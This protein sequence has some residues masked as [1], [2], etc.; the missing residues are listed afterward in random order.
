MHPSQ[1]KLSRNCH[2]R[3][4]VTC[5][6]AS[7]SEPRFASPPPDGDHAATKFSWTV[8]VQCGDPSVA[9]V[10]AT[11]STETSRNGWFGMPDNVAFDAQ[12]RLWIAT[13]GNA[14]SKTGRVDG[15]WGV[16]TEGSQRGTSKHFYRVPVGAEMCGPFFTPDDET[17]F[18]AVRHPG[19]SDEGD[20]NAPPAT[21]E[22]RQRA[23]RTSSLACRHGLQSLP[24]RGGA[25]ARSC[26]E[27]LTV[28]SH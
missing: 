1:R 13:D 14:K 22:A 5:N 4:I 24:S 12:G 10:G 26:R 8:L 7:Y 20:P 19:E 6:Q 25:A 27:L 11:F 16:E 18:V 9:A 15:L 28:K 17:L 23:G 3:R 21:F 2:P